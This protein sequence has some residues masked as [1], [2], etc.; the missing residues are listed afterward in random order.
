LAKNE[1][2]QNQKI[3]R[4]VYFSDVTKVNKRSIEIGLHHKSRVISDTK[5]HKK[6]L[7]TLKV[8]KF[9]LFENIYLITPDDEKFEKLKR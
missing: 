9:Q 5:S 4:E 3:F 2:I 6:A 7:I 8:V 1:F